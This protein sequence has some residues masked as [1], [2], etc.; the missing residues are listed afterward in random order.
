MTSQCV[1]ET[2]AGLNKTFPFPAFLNKPSGKIQMGEFTLSC[3]VFYTLFL[4]LLLSKVIEKRA[5]RMY[6]LMLLMMRST[7][8]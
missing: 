6:L 2:S 1:T 7:L 8:S 4:I 3:C 5:G